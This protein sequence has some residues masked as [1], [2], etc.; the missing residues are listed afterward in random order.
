M[1]VF[2]AAI[3][4]GIEHMKPPNISRRLYDFP[5]NISVR[6]PDSIFYVSKLGVSFL[7]FYGV[8]SPRTWKL[9]STESFLGGEDLFQPWTAWTDTGGRGCGVFVVRLG[10]TPQLTKNLSIYNMTSILHLSIYLS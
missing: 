6:K 1:R 5:P 4:V 3:S 2:K 8:C 10:I 9:S 7:S